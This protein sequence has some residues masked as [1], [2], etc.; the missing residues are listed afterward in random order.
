HIHRAGASA[1]A[2][3][4]CPPGFSAAQV[5]ADR[6]HR[7]ARQGDLHC[8]RFGGLAAGAVAQRQHGPA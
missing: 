5:R 7:P 4:S 2:R 1:A 6:D 3:T 8:Q